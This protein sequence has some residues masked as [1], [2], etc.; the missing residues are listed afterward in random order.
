MVDI[1]VSDDRGFPSDD[2]GMLMSRLQTPSIYTSVRML[3]F[4]E[5]L[6]LPATFLGVRR[7]FHVCVAAPQI[8]L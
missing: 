3:D 4:L 7:A 1:A 6:P 8:A 5:N 2:Q